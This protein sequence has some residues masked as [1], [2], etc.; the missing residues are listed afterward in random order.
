MKL[1]RPM[2]TTSA[3]RFSSSRQNRVGRAGAGCWIFTNGVRV[4]VNNRWYDSLHW[5]RGKDA[6]KLMT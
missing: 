2:S 6:T 1:L 3:L 4:S 5:L